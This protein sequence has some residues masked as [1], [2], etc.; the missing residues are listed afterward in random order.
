MEKLYTMKEVAEILHL[1]KQTTLRFAREGKLKVVK[2][3]R[4]YLVKEQDLQGYLDGAGKVEKLSTPS[5]VDTETT[6]QV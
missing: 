6:V 5:T 2:A 4:H 1:N 3:G